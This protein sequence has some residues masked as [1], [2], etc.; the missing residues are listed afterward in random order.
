MERSKAAG[1]LSFGG[2]K[3]N[4]RDHVDCAF[5]EAKGRLRTRRGP[6]EL[7]AGKD[8]FDP[9]LSSL[10]EVEFLLLTYLSY[11][12]DDRLSCMPWGYKYLDLDSRVSSCETKFKYCDGEHGGIPQ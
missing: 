8:T 5:Q 9:G 1:C 7:V 11:S 10:E 4:E 3:E 12:F 6:G 2:K